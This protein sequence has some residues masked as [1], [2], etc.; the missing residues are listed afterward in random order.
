MNGNSDRAEALKVM[1][2]A[3]GLTFVAE[4]GDRSQ[5]AT[6]AL[7][8]DRGGAG[9]FVTL[10]GVCGHF[11]CTSL[12]VLGGRFLATSISERTVLLSGGTLFLLFALHG[13][14]VITVPED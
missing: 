14:L 5:V 13:A 9:L 10:G 1:A 7:A 11:C 6:I 2:K 8:A 4:W 12:A 3:L